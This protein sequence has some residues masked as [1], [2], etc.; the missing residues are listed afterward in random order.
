MSSEKA[1]AKAIDLAI[2][3]IADD[4]LKAV[5]MLDWHGRVASIENGRVY[6]NAGRL[7]GLEKGSV[8]EVYALGDQ[9]VD[10]KTKM[11]LGNV[12]GAYKGEIEVTELFGVDASAA[13]VVKG[14]NFSATDLVYSKQ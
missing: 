12:K 14:T 4:L 7:S 3:I 10:A 8:L 11:P 6:L 9:I 2:E 1:K 5:L 13:K